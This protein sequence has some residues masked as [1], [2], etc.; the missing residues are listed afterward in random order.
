M[1][2]QLGPRGEGSSAEHV[3]RSPLWEFHARVPLQDVAGEV[4]L[5][6]VARDPVQLNQRQFNFR[7]PRNNRLLGRGTV[8]GQEKVV[9]EADAR[10]EQLA[11]A[12]SPI[13]SN[14]ALQHVTDVVEFVSGGLGWCEHAQRFAI[15]LVVGVE[16]SAGLL[17]RDHLVNDFLGRRTQVRTIAGLQR[18]PNCFGPLVN[19][20]VRKNRPALRGVA[21]AHQ[22]AEIVHA[23]VGFEQIVHGGNAFGEVNLPAAR[24]EAA[25]DRDRVHRNVSE[26]R[27]RRLGE[28]LDALILPSGVIC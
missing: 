15:V 20:G 1:T 19:I 11:V 4:E 21:L 9:H 28:I 10:V 12:S 25:L 26:F 23:P 16:V 14:C 5:P 22:T 18:E 24:P 6:F 2:F 17:D 13:V 3:N 7:M 27:V 8:V